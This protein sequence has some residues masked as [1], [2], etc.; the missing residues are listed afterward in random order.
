MAKRVDIEYECCSIRAKVTY[1]VFFNK[2]TYIALTKIQ[3][4]SIM[5]IN[6]KNG[7]YNGFK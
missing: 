7:M 4:S 5:I 1:A 6:S 3:S 2:L